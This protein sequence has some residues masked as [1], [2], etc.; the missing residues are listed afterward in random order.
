LNHS[1]SAC[2]TSVGENSFCT[3]ESFQIRNMQIF[4]HPAGGNIDN[5][6]DGEC[7]DVSLF[8]GS[9]SFSEYDIEVEDTVTEALDE[10]GGPILEATEAAAGPRPAGAGAGASTGAGSGANSGS[11]TSDDT[12]AQLRVVE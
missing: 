8:S 3:L 11:S 12:D 9:N 4:G 2:D 6:G 5:N 10:E 7:C 1:S